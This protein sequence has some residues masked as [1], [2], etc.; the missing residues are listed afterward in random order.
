MAFEVISH[1][2]GAFH[3]VEF[4]QSDHLKEF[5]AGYVVNDGAVFD[6]GHEQFVALSFLFACLG[7]AVGLVVGVHI[8]FV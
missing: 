6:G 4:E 3:I 5:H 8:V 7:L 2:D 1:H